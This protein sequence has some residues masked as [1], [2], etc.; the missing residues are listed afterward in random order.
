MNY[1]AVYKVIDRIEINQ[2][3][4]EGDTRTKLSDREIIHGVTFTDYVA[5][6]VHLPEQTIKILKSEPFIK[7]IGTVKELRYSSLNKYEKEL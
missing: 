1:R 5:T 6:D 3:Y 2:A 7:E 4:I